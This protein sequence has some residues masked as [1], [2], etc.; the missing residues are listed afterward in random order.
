MF[1]ASLAAARAASAAA[2]IPP[3]DRRSANTGTPSTTRPSSMQSIPRTSRQPGNDPPDP[4][5]SGDPSEVESVVDLDR[6]PGLYQ[7]FKHLAKPVELLN[8]PK[9]R[10]RPG[11]RTRVKQ[12]LNKV[13][14]MAVQQAIDY[15]FQGIASSI[16]NAVA[17][18][19]KDQVRALDLQ[20]R[21]EL[22]E[23]RREKELLRYERQMARREMESA[24]HLMNRVERLEENERIS[25][26]VST[27]KKDGIFPNLTYPDFDADEDLVR[28]SVIALAAAIKVIERQNTYEK[29]PYNFIL[30]VAL[31]ANKVAA[32]HKLSAPQQRELVLNALPIDFRRN[33]YSMTSN[34]EELYQVISVLAPSILTISD[35]EKAINK[36]HLDNSSDKMLVNTVTQLIDLLIRSAQ[37]RNRDAEVD[38]PEIFRQ[39]IGRIQRDDGIPHDIYQ[40]LSEARIRIRQS[41]TIPELNNYLFGAL[42]P[43]IGRQPKKGKNQNQNASQGAIPKVNKVDGGGKNK[44]NKV[45]A[46]EQAPPPPQQPQQPPVQQDSKGGQS[47]Q[48]GNAKN[49]QNWKGKNKQ[50]DRK[51]NFVKPWPEGKSYLSKNGN[52]LT[53]E[54]EEHFH[55]FCFRCGHNSHSG[56]TCK[57]YKS[58]DPIITLCTRCRQGFHDSCK[59]KRW[60]LKE[61]LINK[62][63]QEVTTLCQNLALAQHAALGT[64][65]TQGKVSNNPAISHDSDD[66]D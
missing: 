18:S 42:N 52:S 15:E 41:N 65:S 17:T 28:K 32:I 14:P 36:W 16:E 39:A 55:G 26:R 24:R 47:K 22:E 27:E 23:V 8:N 10:D 51:Y 66:S 4:G 61:E 29:D 31:E 50:G 12:H 46:I 62:K 13:T 34:L 56:D 30:F 40:A 44:K 2:A 49:K 19:V 54:V 58:K 9:T 11:T 57:V 7:N 3:A 64:H 53:R 63:L 59:S 21:K 38:Y 48:D 6:R 5:P 1:N 60:G 35:L 37:H 20:L 25:S 33:Y 45:K 43:F